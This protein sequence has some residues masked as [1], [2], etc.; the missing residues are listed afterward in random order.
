MAKMEGSFV[1][2][3]G[4]AELELQKKEADFERTAQV[5]REDRTR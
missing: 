4:A 2:Q 3:G 1:G 5:D